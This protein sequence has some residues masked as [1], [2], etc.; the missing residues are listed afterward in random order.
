MKCAY[1]FRFFLE[2]LWFPLN[3][4]TTENVRE[5]LVEIVGIE[6]KYLEEEVDIKIPGEKSSK[7][8]SREKF[9]RS[10]GL[11]DEGIGGGRERGP[12]AD[13]AP[14]GTPGLREGRKS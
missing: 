9:L 7:N 6:G 8:K 4:K 10:V 14:G 12:S 2:E 13:T 5:F 11:G 1:K 3:S